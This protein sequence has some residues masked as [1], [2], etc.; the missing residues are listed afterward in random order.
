[1][2]F[3]ISF[4]SEHVFLSNSSQ[5]KGSR[6]TFAFVSVMALSKPVFL[7]RDG[8]VRMAYIGCGDIIDLNKGLDDWAQPVK[9]SVDELGE[10]TKAELF[11]LANVGFGCGA[12]KGMKKIDIIGVI[13]EKWNDIVARVKRVSQRKFDKKQSSLYSADQSNAEPASPSGSSDGDVDADFDY[14]ILSHIPTEYLEDPTSFDEA[15]VKSKKPSVLVAFYEPYGKYLFNLRVENPFITVS[16]L[17][18]MMVEKISSFKTADLKKM[19]KPENIDLIFDHEKLSDNFIFA[20]Y[21]T[22]GDTKVD[23]EVSLK[24]KGGGKRGRIVERDESVMFA[25]TALPVDIEAV[26]DALKLTS[27][28]LGAWVKSLGA[29]DLV[30]LVK[31]LDDAPRSGVLSAQIAPCLPFIREYQ[32]LTVS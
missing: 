22:W 23:L 6:D 17:K 2:T 24:L 7:I 25:P 16:E 29:D 11:R 12:Q 14:Y 31:G 19:L 3:D 20:H 1:M 27:I 18:E 4:Q 26:K 13:D 10:Y 32:N 9:P 30:K 15:I 28:N 5:G 8:D 21:L